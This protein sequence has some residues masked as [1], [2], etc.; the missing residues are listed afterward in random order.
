MP[1][2]MS[3]IE[4]AGCPETGEATTRLLNDASVRVAFLLEQARNWRYKLV[5]GSSTR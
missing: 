5:L 4:S 2:D 1:R 3:V